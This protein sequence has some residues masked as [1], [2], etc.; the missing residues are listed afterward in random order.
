MGFEPREKIKDFWRKTLRPWLQ[1]YQWPLVGGLALLAGVLGFLGFRQLYLSRGEAHT[2]GDIFYLTLQLFS[3]KSGAVSGPKP[4]ELELARFLALSL[5]AFA[6]AKALLV[7]FH[8]QF[9]LLKL[10]FLKNHVVICGLGRKGLTMAREFRQAGKKVVVLEH[11]GHNPLLSDCRNLKVLV[12]LG[13]A[14]N[15]DH[16]RK[17]RLLK[18]RHLIAVCGDDGA[19]VEIAVHAAGLLGDHP[20]KALNCFVHLV[21]PDL[22]RLLREREIITGK[23][24]FFRQEFFNIYDSGA[25]ALLK[26]H[27]DSS[28]SWK[29]AARPPHLLII[30]LGAMGRSLVLHAARAG[31]G[32]YRRTGVPLR[33]TLVDRKAPDKVEALALSYPRLNEACR[34]TALKMDVQSLEF[35]K[36]DFL[37][38]KQG[39]CDLTDVHV[40]FDNDTLG[41]TTALTLYQKLRNRPIP[42][43][44]RMGHEAG[45]AGLL[46]GIAGCGSGFSNVQVFGLLDRSCR[47]E[48]VLGGTHEVMARAIHENYVKECLEEGQTLETNSSLV[49]WEVLPEYLKESNRQQ[50]DHIGVKLKAVNCGIAPLTDWEAGDFQ[51]SD[52]E[53]ILLAQMEHTRFMEEKKA[54]GWIYGPGKKDPKR[55]THPCLLSWDGL[56]PE[57]QIKDINTVRG[58]PAFLSRVDLQIYRLNQCE[59]PAE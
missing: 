5:T 28:G 44:V 4:W 48:V 13:N 59:Q 35:K 21:D 10:R 37:W 17:A 2:L 9:Q 52:E 12:I 11:D 24:P 34:I 38:D 32:H 22:C 16:L 3:M 18:A 19:N 50:A 31:W 23:L 43:V 7:I 33:L 40:C 14:A 42:I 45:L 57:E 20:D 27:L 29:S 51:F 1:D 55:K 46:Q 41:L 36:G 39:N 53:V 30:G 49:P 56:P 58:L 8:Q 25:R 26:D 47:P 6:A 54:A 15:K